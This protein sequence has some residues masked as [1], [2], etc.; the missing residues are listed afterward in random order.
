MMSCITGKR[1]V[2][3]QLKFLPLN[4]LNMTCWML[5]HQKRR[6]PIA[7]VKIIQCSCVKVDLN[8][9]V[10]AQ[11]FLIHW[12][13]KHEQ[14]RVLARANCFTYNVDPDP[15]TRSTHLR[16]RFHIIHQFYVIASSSCTKLYIHNFSQLNEPIMHKNCL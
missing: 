10:S 4:W 15:L 9:S 13:Y 7:K 12:T 16:S 5:L 1:K 3:T 2:L 14:V 6:Q 8:V 11:D